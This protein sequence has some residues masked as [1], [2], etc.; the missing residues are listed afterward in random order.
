MTFFLT[1]LAFDADIFFREIPHSMSLLSISFSIMSEGF[2]GSNPG[3]QAISVLVR[4]Q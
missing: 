2:G 4:I 1:D 3:H